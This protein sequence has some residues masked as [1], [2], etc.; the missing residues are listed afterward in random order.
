MKA[1]FIILAA[2]IVFW[3]GIVVAYYE[4]WPAAAVVTVVGVVLGF[5][6]GLID[7]V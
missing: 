6:N 1:G 7:L 4:V 3:V 2:V 5:V